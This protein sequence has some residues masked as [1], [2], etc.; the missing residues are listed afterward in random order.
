MKTEVRWLMALAVAVLLMAGHAAYAADPV[1]TTITIPGMHCGGCAK[2]VA[3]KLVEVQGVAKAEPNVEAKTIKVTPRANVVL[4][5]KALW[6]A[7]EK[8][9][10]EPKKLEGP[11][12]TF[13]S[14]PKQ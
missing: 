7:V 3:T 11:S 5:P 14:K 4:S 1:P 9:D 2:K 8:A 10:Q 12:G 6:E 13:T